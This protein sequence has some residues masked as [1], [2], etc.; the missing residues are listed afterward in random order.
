M[1]IYILCSQILEDGTVVR[2]V[3]L[4]VREP[5]EMP[6]KRQI[7]DYLATGIEMHEDDPNVNPFEWT[8]KKTIQ[9]FLEYNG[10][11]RYYR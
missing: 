4:F 2:E 5:E 7:E 11:N 10:R 6:N 1:A 9:E 8:M 3:P